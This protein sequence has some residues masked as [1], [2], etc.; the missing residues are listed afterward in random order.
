MQKKF[1]KS[2]SLILVFCFIFT[3]TSSAFASASITERLYNDNNDTIE[4]TDKSGVNYR[5]EVYEKGDTVLSKQYE[6]GIL[7]CTN[8]MK[9]GGTVIKQVEGDKVSYLD[10]SDQIEQI[11][12]PALYTSRSSYDK[13]GTME[14]D[15]DGNKIDVYSKEGRAKQTT[16]EVKSFTGKVIS[17]ATIL[18]GALNLPAA[19]AKTLVRRLIYG[20]LITIA[21]DMVTKILGVE[22]LAS[23]KTPIYW[24]VMDKYDRDNCETFT[25]YKYVI[26][27]SD[28]DLFEEVFSQGYI[29]DDYDSQPF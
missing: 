27:E 24:K 12:A 16:Y 7:T 2:I 6:N 5:I 4:F 3:T 23:T 15:V 17:F 20:A 14:Y 19:I 22:T 18:A 25:G 21:G 10:Y 29:E 8:E 13:I 1:M 11:D 9:K 26:N 28:H